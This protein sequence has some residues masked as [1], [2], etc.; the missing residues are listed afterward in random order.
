MLKRTAAVLAALVLL[1]VSQSAWP[2]ALPPTHP[3]GGGGGNGPGGSSSSGPPQYG[4][5]NNCSIYATSI[6]VEAR[7]T[8]SIPTTLLGLVG[9]ANLTVVGDAKARPFE[10]IT[11]AD[12][13]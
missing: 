9:K 4:H 10:G 12:A 11:A 3:P 6:V 5:V 2:D 7:V 8:M 13:C 1:G